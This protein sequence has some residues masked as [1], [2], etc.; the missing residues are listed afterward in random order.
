VVNFNRNIAETVHCVVTDLIMG[1]NVTRHKRT[2]SS[3][4]LRRVALVRIDVSEELSVSFI[5]FLRNVRLLLV[6]VSV[7][8]SSRILITLMKEE[9]S[10]SETF[11][12]TRAARCNVPEDAI[13]HSH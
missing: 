1:K 2:E 12:L 4:I 11:V 3:G 5:S 13:F 9:L 8:P 10:S 7:L 6:T